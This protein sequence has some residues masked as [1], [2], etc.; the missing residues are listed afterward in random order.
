MSPTAATVITDGASK[1]SSLAEISGL[2]G[3]KRRNNKIN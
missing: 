2:K 3:R 1:G